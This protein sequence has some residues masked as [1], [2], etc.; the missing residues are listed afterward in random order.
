MYPRAGASVG[1]SGWTGMSDSSDVD[2][3]IG[4]RRLSD[5]P[6]AVRMRRHRLLRKQGKMVVPVQV[7]EQDIDTLQRAGH[8]DVRIERDDPVSAY[9][10]A[11]TSLLAAVSEE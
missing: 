5:A 4:R 11:L 1:Q 8:L 3:G 10:E 7:S 9:R 2:H 6:S